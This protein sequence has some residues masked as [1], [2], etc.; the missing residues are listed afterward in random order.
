VQPGGSTR[1]SFL[2]GNG[3]EGFQLVNIHKR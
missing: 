3:Q 1:E 2:F